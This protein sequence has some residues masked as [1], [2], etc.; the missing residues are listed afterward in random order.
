MLVSPATADEAARRREQPAF[1]GGEHGQI[2]TD[3]V[4]LKFDGRTVRGA[5]F[6]VAG[7]PD[8]CVTV[9]LGYGRTRAGRV[10][11]GAGFNA[12][13]LRTADAL[14]FGARRR[15]RDAPATRSRSPAR[16]ITT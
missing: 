2:I 10:A 13:A 8:D 1:Q 15:D 14:S 4:E 12:N 5:L 7:H 6:A 16:S 11:D 3:V 9:H